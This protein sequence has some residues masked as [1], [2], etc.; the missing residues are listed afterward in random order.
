MLIV[1]FGMVVKGMNKGCDKVVC[2]IIEKV[3]VKMIM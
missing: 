2:V 3:I 1:V